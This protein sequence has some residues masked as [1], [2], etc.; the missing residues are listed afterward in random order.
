MKTQHTAT[1]LLAL[2]VLL[3]LPSSAQHPN[4]EHGYVP[5]RVYEFGEIDSVNMF[6]GNLTLQIPIGIEYPVGDGL[7]YQ[8][9]LSYNS[10]VWDF[11]AIGA[12]GL[13]GQVTASPDQQSNAGLGWRL[14]FG[15]MIPAN[16][17]PS[18]EAN[19]DYYVSPS[20][21]TSKVGGSA[22]TANSGDGTYLRRKRL[23]GGGFTIEFPNG[24]I[25]TFDAQGRLIEMRD[26][27]SDA[28]P[29]ATENKVTISYSSS[30]NLWTIDDGHRQ[31]KVTLVPKTVDGQTIYYVD[32]VRLA[33]FGDP[34][35]TQS[36]VYQF[37]Y[38]QGQIGQPQGANA[39]PTSY[40]AQFL[41]Q[42]ELPHGSD[43]RMTYDASI[44]EPHPGPYAQEGSLLSMQLPTLGRI[45]WTYDTWLLP[46]RHCPTGS[47]PV[48]PFSESVGVKTRS[49]YSRTGGFLG[50]WTYDSMPEA[51]IG[52]S[53]CDPQNPTAN[54]RF[55]VLT[56]TVQ[57]PEGNTT[58]NY[59][60]VWDG[61]NPS[62]AGYTKDW[63]AAPF[64]KEETYGSLSISR[65]VYDCVV[66]PLQLA[67]FAGWQPPCGGRERGFY[68]LYEQD[69]AS[70]SSG[71]GCTGVN[72]R[73]RHDTV[74][75]DDDGHGPTGQPRVVDTTRSQW[76]GRGHYRKVIR[77]GF[78]NLGTGNTFGN[79]REEF[80]N[81]VAPTG[82][83]GNGLPGNSSPWLLNLYD[84]KS[85][86]E[87]GN[88]ATTLYSFNNSTGFL[89][90]VRRLRVNGTSAG[91]F[92]LLTTFARDKVNR[93]K[94]EIRE[95][96]YGG[97]TTQ[98]PGSTGCGAGNSS[99][100]YRL[101]K[102]FLY[103]VLETDRYVEAGGGTANLGFYNQ[104]YVLDSATGIVQRSFDV[105]DVRVDFEYDLLG[106][107]TAVKPY[108][109]DG[110]GAFEPDAAIQL[111][112][113]QATASRPTEV[114][115]RFWGFHSPYSNIRAISK[116]QLDGF[117]RKAAE[118]RRAPGYS[119]PHW[120]MK[121]TIYDALGR[122]ESI[123]ELE[124][125]PD[126]SED[127]A[128][129][130]ERTRFENY[131]AFGRATQIRSPDNKITTLNYGGDRTVERIVR[132]A[133]TPGSTAE[134]ATSR[135]ERYDSHGR[136]LEVDESSGPGNSNVTTSYSYHVTNN[137]A[138]VSMPGQTRS[139]TY[140]NRG[141]LLSDQQPETGP[142]AYS[143]YDAMGNVGRKRAGWNGSAYTYDT[144][145][146][147]DRASRIVESRE[148][149]ENR[150]LQ[151]FF[152]KTSNGSTGGVNKRK[153]KLYWTRK[154]NYVR[155]PN[156]TTSEAR[157]DQ[158]LVYQ[159]R[160][161]RLRNRETR[162]YVNGVLNEFFDQRWDLTPIGQND[163]IYRPWCTHAACADP[164]QSTYSAAASDR[165]SYYRPRYDLGF[166]DEITGYISGNT[167]NYISN[168]SYHDNL[169]PFQVTHANGVSTEYGK[170]QNR[171]G[172]PSYIRTVGASSNWNP[173]AF[174]YQYDGAG[175][176]KREGL[177]EYTYDHAGRLVDAKVRL[178]Q[179]GGGSMVL[180]TYTYDIYGNMTSQGGGVVTEVHS[181]SNML[182]DT[183]GPW[184]HD[185]HNPANPK[186]VY[187]YA[188]NLTK[189]DGTLY[190]RDGLG[191]VVNMERG[192]FPNHSEF[193][194]LAYTAD[195]ERVWEYDMVTNSSRW[196]LRDLDGRPLAVLKNDAGQWSREVDHLYRGTT[197]VMSDT[198]TDGL[199]HQHTDHLGTP[200]FVT[201]ATGQ[202]K[203][204]NVF[205]PFG[206][207]ASPPSSNHERRLLYTGH[208]RDFHLS[209]AGDDVDYMLARYQAPRYSRFLSPDPIES[210]D[211]GMPQSWNK[212]AY[213]RN[214]PLTYSDPDGRILET[215]WD[216]GN[217][218]LGV[219]S[220]ISNFSSGN[221]GAGLIDAG[222]AA[223][224]GL[225]A[226]VPFVPGGFSTAVKA[227]RTA[228]T[229]VDASRSASHLG[230]G[231]R[232][233]RVSAS[234]K[235]GSSGGPGAGKRFSDAT[236]DKAEAEAGGTC[237]FCGTE[238]SRS[239]GPT[240][241]NTDHA[242]PKS[243]G[244]NNTL[245]N[246]QNTCRTC[247]LKKRAKT[248]EEFLRENK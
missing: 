65:E 240:Q 156:G 236:K 219:G 7:S 213:V 145:Y 117:G 238:T 17:D 14:G 154:H 10:K 2:L 79:T 127:N 61:D 110:S 22:T 108:D 113:R 76:D 121:Q 75:Y 149:P 120:A 124:T 153:G 26:R 27:L 50:T 100:S 102:T 201:S 205:L 139:F 171:M 6:N 99:A 165:F 210:A 41:K 230:D 39:G 92:D 176:V 185:P 194:L 35:G 96:Y 146:A 116:V 95:C 172:R 72:R 18:M 222:A 31:H 13:A 123:S 122:V 246:A 184:P 81:Y 107:V 162:L 78:R 164:M 55:E 183:T 48:H 203:E 111:V 133:T 126:G 11:E 23:S 241:R 193:M 141:F 215:A 204:H 163:K 129:I 28:D 43:F 25:H 161:G 131:D 242:V 152:Y 36:A 187:D 5:E 16:S 62:L 235:P 85:V 128:F 226:A 206:E 112:H 234:P 147:Y 98:V 244:G 74:A 137:L 229:L 179:Q 159:G 211:P 168:I 135:L 130:S 245:E 109:V 173:S 239:A 105:A 58:A 32:E 42:I 192:S 224:D 3:A 69:G 142:T 73:L 214:N 38:Q 1:L 4:V 223:L 88:Q 44:Y 24:D 34:Y 67:R 21:G 160:G 86:T 170:D 182:K 77:S 20:G 94:T 227:G 119:T 80:T 54:G 84:R 40:T 115:L 247:N 218:V 29:A 82:G 155:L 47:S 169:Q 90:S 186:F 83:P 70:C 177:S 87:Q 134:T 106:R 136:L 151:R 12:G 101:D 63:Y 188:G 125:F 178:G 232:V 190:H 220:A 66:T 9:V 57:D 8:L 200:R 52:G 91:A 89:Q 33:A 197:L 150:Y 118:Q 217:A 221:V 196:T 209:G 174:Q 216:L 45:E 228:D 191:A 158:V 15:H 225:A 180:R 140:D 138:S 104:R 143:D 208:E 148:Q 53:V 233:G 237:V 60:S 103:G 166:L 19:R 68:V 30:G 248:T 189:L 175:N 157:I 144:T 51:P 93:A 207:E 37:L 198:A 167:S 56:S 114:E 132:V 97:D 243:R 202:S 59:F 71:G 181:G 46:A 49:H 199:L 212:Y 231:S 64:R 195:G